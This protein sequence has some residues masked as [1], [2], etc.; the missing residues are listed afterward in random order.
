[1]KKAVIHECRPSDQD[2]RPADEQKWCLYTSDGDRLLGRHPSKDK[3][4]NQERAIQVNK[5]SSL[6][7]SLIRLAH[8]KPEIRSEILPLLGKTAE[9]GQGELDELYGDMMEALADM[10]SKKAQEVVDTLLDADEKVSDIENLIQE[11]AK[12]VAEN[13][14]LT[15]KGASDYLKKKSR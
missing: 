15:A 1:M 6:R 3:A 14:K 5:H 12:E 10:N 7:R 9:V 2:D 13:A 8:E 4:E 11:A